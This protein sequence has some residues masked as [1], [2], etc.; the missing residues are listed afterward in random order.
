MQAGD[1]ADGP[2][3]DI[4]RSL[5]ADGA[6]GGLHVR[7][8]DGQ[9]DAGSARSPSDA[10]LYLRDGRLYAATAPGPRPLLGVRLVAAGAVTREA[11]EEALESQKGELAGWRLGELL[12]HLGYV[13]AE[14]VAEF[15]VEQILDTI[16][17][18]SAWGAGGWRFRSG[19]R[20]REPD[21][22]AVDIDDVLSQVH[23][24]RLS[25]QDL[26]VSAGGAGAVPLRVSYDDQLATEQIPLAQTLLTDI[27]GHRT[28]AELATRCGL[29]TYEAGYVLSHLVDSGLVVLSDPVTGDEPSPTVLDEAFAL[30]EAS[31][32]AVDLATQLAVLARQ[33]EE[34]RWATEARQHSELAARRREVSAPRLSP[35]ELSPLE[36]SPVQPEPRPISLA[37]REEPAL[38]LAPLAE[39]EFGLAPLD[40]PELGESSVAD[41]DEAPTDDE[42]PGRWDEGGSSAEPPHRRTGPSIGDPSEF[43]PTVPPADDQAAIRAALAEVAAGSFAAALDAEVAAASKP[44][45]ASL[46][47]SVTPPAATDYA[48]GADELGPVADTASLLRELSFLGLDDAPASATTAPRSLPAR[49]AVAAKPKRKSIF[50]R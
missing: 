10:I 40:E 3:A 33:A 9:A 1:L 17:E 32:P 47:P 26:E 14:I 35:V 24:R 41:V 48:P 23:V 5:A 44:A 34:A 39:P 29:T 15:V 42:L 22:L 7:R 49:P 11:L 19:E 37:P 12:V 46:A 8:R 25:W 21:G 28:L 2:L 50:G 30:P 13:D 36:L 43:V 20:T 31:D 38:E 4:L 45:F 27:D 18:V 6:T 16:A